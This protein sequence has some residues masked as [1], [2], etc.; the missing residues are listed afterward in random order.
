MSF[1]TP[2]ETPRRR[3]RIWSPPLSGSYP[4]SAWA[5]G[6]RLASC[7]SGSPNASMKACRAFAREHRWRGR[8]SDTPQRGGTAV[9]EAIDRVG[10]EPDSFA[11]F[12]TAA[13]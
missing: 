7:P 11:A 12:G 6:N 5:T 3:S 1:G 4:Y 2:R 9:D 10:R 8:R 13:P